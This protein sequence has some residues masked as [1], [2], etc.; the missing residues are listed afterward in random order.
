MK[1]K[2]TYLVAVLVLVLTGCKTADN[3]L[4]QQE[5]N[6]GWELLFN[7]TNLNGWH[8]Y[9]G[10]SL[11][12]PRSVENG[13]I[14][15]EGH[16]DDLNGYIVT[17]KKYDNFILSWDWKIS[18]GGNSG[19]L[20]HVVQDKKYEVPYLTGPEYQIIDDINFP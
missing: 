4:S 11:T 20:Y 8:D 19:M 16:G 17:E 18:K 10:D 12:G 13:T 3:Q 2:L 6:E 15:A 14:K 7:G 5:K 9:N 1:R